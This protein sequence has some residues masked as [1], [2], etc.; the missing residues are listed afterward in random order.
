MNTEPIGNRRSI[1]RLP[2]G[3][4][5][6][7]L[8]DDA[9]TIEARY[10]H[11]DRGLHA[12]LD[13][14]CAWA[15][16][17]THQG[18]LSCADLNLSS[19][20][21]RR[22]LAKYCAERANTKPEDFDWQ[23]VLDAACL[24]VI[25]ADRQGDEVIRL[26]DAPDVADRDLDIHG[27]KLPADAASLLIAHGDSL[28]SLLTLLVL[29]TLAQRGYDVLYVDWEW[30]ADRHKARK[31]RLFG[32]AR[33]EGLHYLRC[34]APL[35]IE[36][37]RIRR[38]CDT[39]HIAFIGIDSVGMACDGKLIDDDVAIRFHRALSCLPPSLCA[40]HVPK[41]AIAA[42]VKTD[43]QVF[44]S[45]YFS[46][47]CRASWV[48]RKQPGATEDLIT[49]GLFP[50]KQNDGQRSRPVGLEFTFGDRIDVRSIDIA[51]VEGLADRLPLAVRIQHVLKAVRRPLTYAELAD[52]LGAKV[53][54]IIKTTG[55]SPEF[56]KVLGADGVTRIALVSRR[57]G[58]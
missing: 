43:P 12:E 54:T 42:D 18:S 38:F 48:V 50:Q 11:R 34:R 14:R 4:Y 19:Q 28:K 2:G 3:G 33:L 39:A 36:C 29:G 22:A 20:P 47:L 10:L 56:T 1:D 44:G 21:A 49:L 9:I 35:V 57:T 31:L 53:D 23:G 37:D 32:P 6:Y 55:R 7:T 40:A 41:S 13:V 45:V 51:A 26:D 5:V 8:V 16:V 24:S 27:L 25:Q 46:N 52:D 17:R 30:T 15:G 58:S